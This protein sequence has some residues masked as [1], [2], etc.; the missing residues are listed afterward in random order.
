MYRLRRSSFCCGRRLNG[1]HTLPCPQA[2]PGAG[3]Q[4]EE[5]YMERKRREH[6]QLWREDSRGTLD[7]EQLAAERDICPTW[8]DVVLEREQFFAE[9]PDF[10]EPL[11]ETW[12]FEI[13]RGNVSTINQL[14]LQGAK[15]EWVD[16]YGDRAIHLAAIDNSSEVLRLLIAQ[17]ADI[18]AKN[19]LGNTALHI[20][21][22]YAQLGM[23]SDLISAGANLEARNR[24]KATAIVTASVHGHAECV[25]LLA[26]AGADIHTR[27]L[28]DT[29]ALHFAAA[30]N[31]AAAIRAL[32][33]RGADPN[34]TTPL[35]RNAMDWA[36]YSNETAA[37]AELAKYGVPVQDGGMLPRLEL[38]KWAKE[39]QQR[40]QAKLDAQ[41]QG[42][43]EPVQPATTGTASHCKSVAA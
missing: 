12:F 31:H 4:V 41:S 16:E 5:G 2:K 40:A 15:V 39:K 21:T 13:R 23:M 1:P 20:A 9:H 7:P 6:E 42:R 36:Y 25:H 34:A 30:G 43:A 24:A 11:N 3:V 35:G 14:V 18:D 32:I 19:E 38:Q 17:G 33:A 10:I 37:V 29:P 28:K 22:E 27:A 8:E 26:A